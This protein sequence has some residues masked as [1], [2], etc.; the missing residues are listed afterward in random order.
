[1]PGLTITA[2]LL[3]LLVPQLFV[4]V[5]LILPFWPKAPDVTVMEVPL[6]AVIFQPEGTVQLYVLAPE[7]AV[8]L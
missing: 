2:K 6:L 5:T 3:A 8:M 1:M 4:A 7:T